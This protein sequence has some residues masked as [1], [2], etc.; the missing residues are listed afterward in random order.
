MIPKNLRSLLKRAMLTLVFGCTLLTCREAPNYEFDLIIANG[1]VIDGSGSLWFPAD[2]AI[3]GDE[4]VHLGKLVDQEQKSSRLIDAQ[5]LWVTPGIIDIHSHSDYSLLVDGTARSK[6]HQGVTTEIL[7]SGHSAGPLQGKAEL[8]L[9]DYGLTADWSTLGQYFDRLQKEGIAVNVASYVAA[10][11]VRRCLLG[12]APRDPSEPEFAE[13]QH[14]VQQAMLDGALGLSSWLELPPDSHLTTEQLTELA[15][16]VKSYGGIY[17]TNIRNS[18]RSI[19]KALREAF[20]VADEAQIPVDI[21]GLRIADRRRWGQMQQVIDLIEEARQSG[22]AVTANQT[23]YTAVHN[24]LAALMP[25]WALSGGRQEMLKRLARNDLR[26]R[27]NREWKQ[28]RSDGFHRYLAVGSWEGIV[29]ARPNSQKYQSQAGKSIATI[30]ADLGQSASDV[31]FDLLREAKGGVPAVY[32][33]LSEDDLRHALQVPWISIGSDGAAMRSEGVLGQLKSQPQGYGAF[34]RVLGK[35]VREEQDMA[36][37]EAVYKMTGMNAAKAGLQDR[38]LLRVGK[39]ADITIFDAERVRD[40]ATL[41]DPHRY[42]EGIEYVIVN[43]TL[44]IDGGR[45]LDTKPGR[46]LFG[47]G[48]PSN[49][50]RP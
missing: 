50:D 47:P 18:G 22:L 21:V 26:A 10:G 49:E 29:V 37:E 5:G 14:L 40:L 42:S 19:E 9:K 15:R 11:Q 44:V 27:I 48:R 28:R 2:V 7:G 32:H 41:Q 6:V 24:D 35:Y 25:P 45:P 13:M 16:V 33:L 23:P 34:A 12:D 1:N 43:G 3:R 36:L 38:G 20:K 30:A 17:S 39:K 31:V 46:V 4:I 8:D